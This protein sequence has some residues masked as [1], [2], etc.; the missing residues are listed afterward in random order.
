VKGNLE[1]L[2]P[3]NFRDWD[4]W[5][6]SAP[7]ATIFHSVEWARVLTESYGYRP[8]Y[9]SMGINADPPVL[10]PLMEV[11]SFL[12][13]RRGVSLPFSDQCSPLLT[14]NIGPVELKDIV[15]EHGR[16]E[17]WRFV[18]F[19]DGTLFNEADTPAISFY[20]HQ[21]DLTCDLARYL[22]T[23]RHGT[24]SSL[25]K[26]RRAGVSTSF[27]NSDEAMET[28]YR[29]N[30]LTR[31]RH[32]LPP[33]PPEFFK[34]LLDHIIVRRLGIIMTVSHEGRPAAAAVCLHF[35]R[36]AIMKYAAHDLAVQAVRPNN[37]L[38]WEAIRWHAENGFHVLSFGRSDM[39][40]QGLRWFKNG[41]NLKERVL[42]YY[43]YDLKQNC[44]VAQSRPLVDWS[45]RIFS[46]MPV[47]LLR[48]IGR[49][50]YKHMG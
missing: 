35:G 6:A 41:W 8:M 14:H 2:D 23:I 47:P 3:L 46:R 16:R 27:E 36:N 44:T 37:M 42:R 26:A 39:K 49:V 24:R 20:L 43:K 12:T 11:S 48:S 45:P 34:R 5:L 32:G 31:K 13:G 9:F 25:N 7:D 30:C 10:L 1:I 40:N 4:E 29:L 33:Q 15:F 28:F 18:E 17:G 50:L 19:R 21:L 38:V 22:E